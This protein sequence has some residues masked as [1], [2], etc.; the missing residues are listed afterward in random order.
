MC[1][2]VQEALDVEFPHP[3][4]GEEADVEADAGL[5]ARHDP[6]TVKRIKP[7]LTFLPLPS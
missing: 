2:S 4:M 5:S 1:L 6:G 7:H 3:T